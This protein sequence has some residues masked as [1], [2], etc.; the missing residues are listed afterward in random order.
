MISVIED[1]IYTKAKL[2][3][4]ARALE[5][6]RVKHERTINYNMKRSF[7]ALENEILSLEDLPSLADLSGIIEHQN[8]YLERM[9]KTV[10]MDTTEDILPMV[11]DETLVKMA[12]A[13]D[14]DTLVYRLRTL[15]WVSRYIATHIRYINTTTSKA[16]GQMLLESSTT[17]EFHRVI[18]PYFS[19]TA[20]SRAYVIARTESASATNISI[21]ESMKVSDT[22]RDKVVVWNAIVDE[23]TRESHIFMNGETHPFDEGSTFFVPNRDG[24]YDRMPVPGD[25]SYGASAGNIVNCRCFPTYRYT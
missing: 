14:T 16:L 1:G 11:K 3:A 5:R 8:P 12:T 9:F 2:T 19:V 4:V 13:E 18:R 6:I 7:R 10:Y 17:A 15:D 23:R 20:P 21:N 24:G 25:S 22:G